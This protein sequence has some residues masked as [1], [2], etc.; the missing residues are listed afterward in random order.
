MPNA[1]K[2][3]LSTSDNTLRK[4]NFSIGVS[5]DTAYGDTSTTDFWSCIDPPPGGYTLYRYKSSNGPSIF[6]PYDNADLIGLVNMIGSSSSTIEDTLQYIRD[7][8]DLTLCNF[9]YESIITHNLIMCMDYGFNM[10]YPLSGSVSYDLS[11][12]QNNG[13][14]VGGISYNSSNKGIM[15]L[16]GIDGYIDL[17]YSYITEIGTGDVPYTI[18]AWVYVDGIP[19]YTNAGWS[20]CGNA[21]SNG[22]G[23]QL[24]SNAGNNGILV[25]FGYRSNGNFYSNSSLS[26]GTWYHVVGT[27]EVGVS[28]RIYINGVLDVTDTSNTLLVNSTGAFMQIGWASTRITGRYDGNIA[29]VRLY[30]SHLTDEEVLI[31]FNAQKERFGY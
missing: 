8:D 10:C 24:M 18:E 16:D 12:T 29:I 22:I 2:R 14:L 3:S 27:R 30:N 9:K 11:N 15:V 25:N 21:S 1:I 7:E 26:T 5:P 4:G 31:N 17:K 28:R 23:L 20:I 19:G 13:E 6:T